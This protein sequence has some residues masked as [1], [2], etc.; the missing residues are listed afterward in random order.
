MNLLGKILLITNI[1]TDLAIA[2]LLIASLCIENDTYFMVFLS[3]YLIISLYDC[4][5]SFF[6]FY[7]DNGVKKQKY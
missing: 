3:I 4:F 5:I 6:L 7:P 1:L 2:G